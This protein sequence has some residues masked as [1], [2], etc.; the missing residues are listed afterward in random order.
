M[1]IRWPPSS[2][3]P[4][5]AGSTEFFSSS[6][7]D[8]MMELM[9]LDPPFMSLLF[10]STIPLIMPKNTTEKYFDDPNEAVDNKT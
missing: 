7:E 1:L 5:H 8:I 3:K 4:L 9:I 6:I 10:K 2:S